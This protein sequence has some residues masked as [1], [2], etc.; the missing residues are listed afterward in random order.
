MTKIFGLIIKVGVFQ[1]GSVE[2]Q[3][4]RQ[5]VSCWM[6]DGIFNGKIRGVKKTHVDRKSL[7]QHTA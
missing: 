7:M 3:L 6:F 1:K 2:A 4:C 5:V